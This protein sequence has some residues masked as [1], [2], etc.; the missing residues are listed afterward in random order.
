MLPSGVWLKGRAN[1]PTLFVSFCKDGGLSGA[2]FNDEEVNA[3][4]DIGDDLAYD[5]VG[6]ADTEHFAPGG[7][8]PGCDVQILVAP[9]IHD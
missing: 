7:G 9:S 6:I 5:A 8:R 3:V 1:M 4:G 2:K